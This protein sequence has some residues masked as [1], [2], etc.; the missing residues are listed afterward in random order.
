MTFR[1]KDFLGVSLAFL[2]ATGALAEPSVETALA[3]A[4]EVATS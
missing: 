2:L 4:V 1:G 3:S